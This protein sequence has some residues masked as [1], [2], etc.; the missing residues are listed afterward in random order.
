MIRM[1][2]GLSALIG[3]FSCADE[4]LSGYGASETQW[5]LQEIDGTPFDARAILEFP[6]E[7]V[8]RGQAPCNTFQGAQTVPYPWFQAEDI[9]V[10]RMA[11]PDLEAEAMFLTTLQEM[12]LAEVGTDTL[13]LS[14]DAGRKMVFSAQ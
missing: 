8:L 14:N 6:E 5:V 7:G 2:L 11:C 10:T 3:L 12:T 9:A 1:G 4:T 13:F